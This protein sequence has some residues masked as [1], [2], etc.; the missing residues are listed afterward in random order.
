VT[1]G[2]GPGGSAASVEPDS[3]LDAAHAPG[4]IHGDHIEADTFPAPFGMFGQKDFRSAQKARLLAWPQRG[5]GV[6]QAAAR[7][8]FDKYG[9]TLPFR[10]GVDLARRRAHAPAKNGEPIAL[11][12]AAGEMLSFQTNGGVCHVRG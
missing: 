7:L 10:N 1:S 9:Q 12:G 6:G 3:V 2:A 11:Q 4:G 5:R 8:D